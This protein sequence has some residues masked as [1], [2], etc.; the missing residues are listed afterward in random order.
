MLHCLLQ[1]LKGPRKKPVNY[2]KLAVIDQGPQ[3][4]PI[5]RVESLRKAIVNFTDLD[6]SD[7][8][9]GPIVLKNKFITPICSRLGKEVTE[10][11]HGSF[12]Q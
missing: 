4:N 10:V 12:H 6:A 11:G 3:K 2:N 9:A 7:P 1:G 8:L 5:A